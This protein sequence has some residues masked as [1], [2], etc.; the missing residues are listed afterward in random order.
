MAMI[1]AG[2]TIRNLFNHK[3]TST[4]T[5]LGVAL[6]VFVFT[7]VLMLADGLFKTLV[8]TG[9]DDNIVVIRK[10]SQSEV[11]SIVSGEQADIVSTFPEIKI[12]ADAKPEWT[13][14]LYTIVSLPKRNEEGT[15]NIAVR[16]VTP[17]SLTLRPDIK[18]IEG[19]MYNPGTAEVI[20]GSSVSTR[21]KGT[22]V[23]E[24]VR[25]NAR[26]WQVVG[27]FDAGG[28]AFDSELWG[29]IQQM[30]D[31][32]RR[33][34]YLSSMTLKLNDPSQL[35]AVQSRIE[36]DPRLPLEAKA[37]KDYYAAQSKA[38]TTFIMFV[39]IAICVIFSIGAVVGAAITM[40]ASVANRTKE[41][42]TLRAL[43]FSRFA[44]LTAFMFEAV[45][46]AVAGCV[47]GVGAASL[48]KAI[49]VSTVN[50][51][52]FTELAFNFSL[53]PSAA[54]SALIFA[55]VMGIVGGFFPAVRASR[56]RIVES[57]RT[58]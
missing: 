30:Q 10:A 36:A 58:T 1:P 7:A 2:Y 56:L 23:G 55:L 13:K 52:T 38:T 3:V 39:G 28:T 48:L 22:Q 54:M 18:I 17:V 43:G 41:I 53:T 9:A 32:F 33:G 24:T 15:S 11:T 37:E 50:F 44:I 47:I 6:V 4:L 34:T 27:V 19:R 35:S 51:N 45:L 29:D 57:L 12:G 25:F 20:A 14:E 31:V 42:G 26:D 5:I 49:Q 40:Y 16:G 8:T 21:F 46:I